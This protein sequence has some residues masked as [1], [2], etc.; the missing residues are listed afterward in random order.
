LGEKH[1][2]ENQSV[3]DGF[4]KRYDLAIGTAAKPGA[5]EVGSSP[6]KSLGECGVAVGNADERS[7][8]ESLL[9]RG[10]AITV[11]DM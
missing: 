2:F 10:S 1:I 4:F 6:R 3:K 9:P 5:Y 11:S 7:E 8:L